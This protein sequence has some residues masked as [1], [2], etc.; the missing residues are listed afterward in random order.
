MLMR[1]E[2]RD[3][4]K[5]VSTAGKSPGIENLGL[6]PML[7]GVACVQLLRTGTEAVET[8]WRAGDLCAGALEGSVLRW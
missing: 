7:E 4:T 5:K 3:R 1:V 8:D 2:W 6:S